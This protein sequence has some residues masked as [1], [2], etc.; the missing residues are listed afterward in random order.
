[1]L[2]SFGRT[3]SASI[4][5]ISLIACGGDNPDTYF[6]GSGG[7][8]STASSSS[9]TN[10]TSTSAAINLDKVVLESHITDTDSFTRLVTISDDGNTILLFS[11]SDLVPGSNSVAPTLQAFTLTGGV[12]T[13]VTSFATSS[14]SSDLSKFAFSGD[15]STL[16]WISPQDLVG[17][18]PS[19]NSQIFSSDMAG[20]IT[21]LT[22]S[23]GF[24]ISRV[25]ISS[26]ASLIAF[27]SDADFLGSNPANLPQVYTMDT[28]TLAIT[29]LTSSDT[30][31]GAVYS[32]EISGDGSTIAFVS[33]GDWL[34]GSNAD[35][36][37]QIFTIKADGS[38]FV[39]Q[40]S[41]QLGGVNNFLTVKINKSGSIIAFT[42]AEDYTGQ[43]QDNS[44]QLF[45]VE[46][47][48]S[49]FHQLTRSSDMLRS[50]SFD[51]SENTVFYIVGG[52]MGIQSVDAINPNII[53]PT[54]VM[55]TNPVIHTGLLINTSPP[56]V[57]DN[58]GKIA[59]A[60]DMDIGL[61]VAG[62]S[63][64]QVYSIAP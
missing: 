3:A 4:L 42:S 12:L 46:T 47:A 32:L 9:N 45:S 53:T 57:S 49:T 23:T 31:S 11:S 44:L 60:L 7:G 24:F 16:V 30:S 2:A 41:E 43:N 1:M 56:V 37:I 26:D 28:A 54:I 33:A 62:E 59:W 18:N 27:T 40:T 17:N 48:N 63:I 19:F 15:A 52:P 55:R 34:T 36:L 61:T 6:S 22:N 13:Q 50:D 10:T 35:N 21:Q 14:I 51:I 29:Q 38:Q 25:A 64:R 58:A 20:N 39:Q 5:S 8:S